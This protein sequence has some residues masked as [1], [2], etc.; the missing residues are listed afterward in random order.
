MWLTQ[1]IT[2]H[3]ER[4]NW[5]TTSGG[6]IRKSMLN[7]MPNYSSCWSK[8]ECHTQRPTNTHVGHGSHGRNTGSRFG[9]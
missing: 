9:Y 4:A 5:V 6:G 2:A 3:N 8:V 7:F 1:Y